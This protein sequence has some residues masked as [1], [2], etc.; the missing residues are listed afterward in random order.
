MKEMSKKFRWSFLLMYKH[1][2]MTAL[3]LDIKESKTLINYMSLALHL[4][5]SAHDGNQLLSDIDI[6]HQF[7]LIFHFNSIHAI[8]TLSACR[9]H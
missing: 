1:L 7:P 8:N 9:T 6:G 5:V 3:F 2:L 4:Y